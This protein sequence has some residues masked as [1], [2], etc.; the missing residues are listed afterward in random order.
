MLLR[1][2][3]RSMD[4]LTKLFRYFTLELRGPF[5][6]ASCRMWLTMILLPVLVQTGASGI[7]H[8]QGRGPVPPAVPDG[9]MEFEAAE[10]VKLRVTVVTR[11]L[12]HPWALAFLPDGDMLVTERAGRV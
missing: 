10:N 5:A 9:P 3:A 11:G 8:A 1:M 6:L 2:L 12:S 4:K 7:A